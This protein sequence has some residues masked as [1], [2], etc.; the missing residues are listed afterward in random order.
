MSQ[1]PQKTYL[2]PQDIMQA[3]GENR[4]WFRKVRNAL[5]EDTTWYQPLFAQ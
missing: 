1:L 4:A 2:R 5:E 3:Y